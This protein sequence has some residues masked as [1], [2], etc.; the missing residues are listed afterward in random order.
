MARLR[1]LGAGIVGLAVADELVLRGHRVT[2][3]DPSPGTGASHAAAGM[4]SPAGEAWHGE[5]PLFRLGAESLGLWPRYAARLGVHLHETGTVLAGLDAGDLQMVERQLGVLDL[6]GVGYRR[7]GRRDLRALEPSLGRAAGG[8]LLPGDHSVDPRAMVAALL[9]RL[10]D[11]VVRRPDAGGA[12]D[13]TV[14]ATGAR[15]PEPYA[16]LVRPVRGDI[17][18]VRTD[19]PPAHTVRAWVHGE[20]VYVVPRRRGEDG[21]AEVVVGATSEERDGPLQPTVEGVRRLLDSARRAL[22]G[23]DRAHLVEAIAR[24]RPCTP[25]NHPLVGPTYEP[26]VLLAAGTYRNGVLLAPLVARLVADH[27]ETGFVEAAV[28]P[29]RYLDQRRKES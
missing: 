28:D 22:P 9:A 24:D 11:A 17:L 3:V 26:G 15:L 18:R 13:V 21:Y 5:E 25:D 10:G 12:A 29:R 4:L 2:V 6:A 16:D 20:Q 19:D 27:L 8:A 23:L 14:V 1:V 7:L